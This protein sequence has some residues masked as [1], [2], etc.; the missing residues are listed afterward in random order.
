MIMPKTK[1]V[2]HKAIQKKARSHEVVEL[3]PF[4]EY[5]VISG[6]SGEIYTVLFWQLSDKTIAANCSC[7]WGKYHPRSACSHVLA[8]IDE[9]Y[10]GYT[11]SAW[12][13]FQEARRQHRKIKWIGDGVILT[14]RKN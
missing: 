2:N 8:A 7:N 5:R 3:L 1:I 4:Q 12:Q 13:N 6:H 14:L 10:P 11:P 9:M